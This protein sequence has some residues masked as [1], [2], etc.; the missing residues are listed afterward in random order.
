MGVASQCLYQ[1]AV[2]IE[3]VIATHPYKL[4]LYNKSKQDDK[5]TLLYNPTIK[6]GE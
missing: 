1:F 5:L 4:K 3:N 6:I 2:C